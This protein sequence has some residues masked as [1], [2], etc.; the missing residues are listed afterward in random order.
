ME[1]FSDNYIPIVSAFI[2]IITGLILYFQLKAIRKS[3]ALEGFNNQ[4]AELNKLDC[5]RDR[6]TIYRNINELIEDDPNKVKRVMILLDQVGTLVNNNL[7]SEKIAIDMYWD[8][9]IKCW[10]ACEK[11]IKKER[12]KKRRIQ[13]ENVTPH[14][15][16]KNLFKSSN[17]FKDVWIAKK[18]LKEIQYKYYPKIK[19]TA[20]D[21]ASTHF[22]NFEKLVWRCER[23]CYNRK[24]DR[25]IRY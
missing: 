1:V 19:P 5:I 3:T 11:M 6:E 17:S 16:H 8:V 15:K 20:F 13:K 4:A 14:N 21:Y 9:V 2:L 25:P 7:V 10:D 24:L 12:S 22:E 23:Y 18:Y